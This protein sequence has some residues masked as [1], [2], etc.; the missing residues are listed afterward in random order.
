MRAL[1]QAIKAAF[2]PI[3]IMSYEQKIAALERELSAI[4]IGNC[5]WIPVEKIAKRKEEITK[6][7]ARIR[8]Q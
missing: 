8:N 6:G 3:P 1:Q 2:K 7:L 4:N 5:D